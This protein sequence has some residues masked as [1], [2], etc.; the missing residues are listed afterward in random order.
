MCLV[1]NAHLVLEVCRLGRGFI[2]ERGL[3]N[4]RNLQVPCSGIPASCVEHGKNTLEFRPQCDWVCS[5]DL[6]WTLGSGSTG[7]ES[8]ISQT[9]SSGYFKK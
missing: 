9:G 7:M 2:C 4:L 5:M 8:C 3:A 1:A 6:S